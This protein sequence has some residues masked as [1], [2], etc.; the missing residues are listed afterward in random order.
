MPIEKPMYFLD[1]WL[2]YEGTAHC[3]QCHHSAGGPTAIR[4][5]AEQVMG[6]S[7]KATVLH[8]L[9]TTS[10]LQNYALSY[11]HD[12]P[13]WC[14][15]I[16]D[17]WATINLWY[18]SYFTSCFYITSIERHPHA[19]PKLWNEF[20]FHLKSKQSEYFPSIIQRSQYN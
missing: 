9:Y 20:S 1:S 14:S 5:W 18:P 4:K 13:Q 15:V 3:G 10:C 2:I 12:G 8:G 7:H 6:H 19:Y 17:L 11:C 16:R